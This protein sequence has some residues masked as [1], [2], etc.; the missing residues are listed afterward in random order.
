M[1]ADTLH[2]RLRSRALDVRLVELRDTCSVRLVATVLFNERVGGRH[3]TSLREREEGEKKRKEEETA[4]A[5]KPEKWKT[6]IRRLQK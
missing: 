4:S 5:N 1:D 3:V 6:I 2:S